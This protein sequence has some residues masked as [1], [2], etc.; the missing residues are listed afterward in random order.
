[1][2]AKKAYM[3]MNQKY[4]DENN[5]YR[6]AD[7]SLAAALQLYKPLIGVD[8]QNPRRAEFLFDQSPELNKLVESFWRG[9]LKVDPRAYFA[10]LREIKARL[11][12]R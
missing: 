10:A 7:L 2:S 3:K 6:T 11:Y 9:E 5:I 1:M 8:R 4:I 12:E